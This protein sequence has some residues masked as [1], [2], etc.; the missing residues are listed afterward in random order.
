M[1]NSLGLGIILRDRII[2]TM[3]REDIQLTAAMIEECLE[4]GKCMTKFQRGIPN[5]NAWT[6]ADW[7]I[8]LV[9]EI[10]DV[11]VMLIAVCDRFGI[12]IDELKTRAAEVCERYEE[13]KTN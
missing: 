5:H 4:L 3:T 10:G 11:L 12:E 6:Y 9:E 1:T 7:R 13:V 2:K 8:S